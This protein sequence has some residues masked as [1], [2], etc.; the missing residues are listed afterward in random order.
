MAAWRPGKDAGEKR[1]SLIG[2]PPDKEIW[3]GVVSDLPDGLLLSSKLLSVYDFV[4]QFD[5]LPDKTK[6]LE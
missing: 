3:Y 6:E 4:P 2:D 5:T 1:P